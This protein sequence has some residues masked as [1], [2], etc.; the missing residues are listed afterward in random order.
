[1]KGT[2]ESSSILAAPII[3]FFCGVLNLVRGPERPLGRPIMSGIRVERVV[4]NR[5]SK[6]AAEVPVTRHDV[7]YAGSQARSCNIEHAC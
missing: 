3:L 7:S 5:C 1:V 2:A 4:V 6:I